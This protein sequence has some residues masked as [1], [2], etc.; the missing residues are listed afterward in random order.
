MAKLSNEVKYRI[1]AEDTD[2]SDKVMICSTIIPSPSNTLKNLAE[3]TFFHS[4][5]IQREFNDKKETIITIFS[6]YF[7]PLLKYINHPALI[8][9]WKLNPD[10][11]AY[12]RNIDAKL[13]TPSEK[14]Y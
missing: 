12:E 13:S 4:S 8:Q 10:A 5:Y 11:A 7:V 14:K 3:N 6:A 9:E 2:N 1:H